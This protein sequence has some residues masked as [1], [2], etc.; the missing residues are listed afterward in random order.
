[1]SSHLLAELAQ[2]ID[3]VVIINHGRLITHQPVADLTARAPGASLE[4]VYL[5]LT[6]PFTDNRIT[7]TS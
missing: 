2:T 5:D 4:Q 6:Q 3:D 1:V 7:E